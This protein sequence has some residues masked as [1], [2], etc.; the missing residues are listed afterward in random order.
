MSSSWDNSTNSQFHENITKHFFLNSWKYVVKGTLW[1]NN[2]TSMQ[3]ISDVM[4]VGIDFIYRFDS[5][6]ISFF[7]SLCFIHTELSRAV[8]SLNCV[9]T[10][11]LCSKSAYCF[12]PLGLSQICPPSLKLRRMVITI[13]RTPE[14][15]RVFQD[16]LNN[17]QHFHWKERRIFREIGK[18][19]WPKNIVLPTEKAG[20][21]SV[22]RGTH[23][24][25]IIESRLA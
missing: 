16:S 4:R 3:L 6:V 12:H 9:S 22:S 2:L 15:F 11:E 8:V 5:L 13:S 21:T 10:N 7:S 24:N 1:M 25:T 19:L 14:L 17:C 23:V 20:S 18:L